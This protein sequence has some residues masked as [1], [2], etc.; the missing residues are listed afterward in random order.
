MWKAVVTGVAVLVLTGPIAAGDSR[1]DEAAALA[2]AR[3]AVKDL[4]A[5]LKD[6]LVS[7]IKAG[8]PVK[9]IEVCKSVAQDLA[10]EASAAHSVAIRRTALKVRNPLN[11]PDDLER[12]ALEDFAAKLAAGADPASL[13]HYETV[14]EGGKTVV[15]YLKAIPT[16]AEPCLA[17]HGSA[18]APEV[19]QAIEAS[20]PEDQA[21]GFKPGDLRGAF[22]VKVEVK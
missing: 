2:E 3:A 14:A 20:Y 16:A 8:G 1:A 15:R 11:A 9:A 6:Q 12:R 4:G 18:L 13:E 19:T 5:K 7:A 17:C 22:S 21:T 10:K